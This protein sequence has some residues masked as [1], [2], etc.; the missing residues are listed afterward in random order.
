MTSKVD[1]AFQS[2]HSAPS[3]EYENTKAVIEALT[4]AKG[5]KAYAMDTAEF[6]TFNGLSWDWIPALPIDASD[7]NL[8]RVGSTVTRDLQTMQNVVHSTGWVSGGAITDNLDGTVAV[9]TGVGLI[10]ATDSALVELFFCDW[11]ANAALSLTDNSRNW[12]LVGYNAGAP[13]VQATAVEPTDF[14][15]Q[16]VLAEIYRSGTDLHINSSKR[17]TVGD[18]AS[19]MMRAMQETMPFANASGGIISDAGSRQFDIAAGTWWNGLTKFTTAAFDGSVDTFNYYYRDGIGGWTETTGNTAINNTQYDDGDGTLGT[20]TANRY[21]VHWVF[22]GVDGNVHVIYGQGDYLIAQAEDARIPASLP[23]EILT[24]S[25]LIGKIIIQKSATTFTS[26]ESA[27]MT[28]FTHS[29]IQTHNELG[30]LQGGTAGEYYHLTSADNTEA[31]AFLN[32]GTSTHTAVDAGLVT[33]GSS[34]DHSGGDGGPI[35]YSA[36]TGSPTTEYNS[37][38]IFA[39][40]NSGSNSSFAALLNGDP[41]NVANSVCTFD[42]VTAGSVATIT[43]TSTSQLGKLRMYNTTRGNSVGLILSA[44]GATFTTTTNVYAAGWRDN[45]VITI[46]D[47]TINTTDWCAIELTSGPTGKSAL[48]ATLTASSATVADGCAVHPIEAFGSSKVHFL[49]CQVA[50]VTITTLALVKMSS[51]VFGLR[52]TGTAAAGVTVTVREMGYLP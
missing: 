36:L 49:S 1:L 27:L 40:T 33:N 28:M 8:A 16:I 42:T 3:H 29:L 19:L 6:G 22:I 52:F 46:K 17:H 51:N 47:P 34:H 2:K 44:T 25:R 31:V 5:A 14:N 23:E 20:L 41:T 11:A 43:P 35:P 48:F 24:D 7:V 12:V 18:H 13:T 37:N 32:G 10:R 9:A 38:N 39:V 4:V 15:T 21:G 45:D 50:G 30:G 26:A